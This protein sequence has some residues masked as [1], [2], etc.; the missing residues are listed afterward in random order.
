MLLSRNVIC[1]WQFQ[2]E[3]TTAM[4]QA[5]HSLLYWPTNLETSPITP[6]TN[7]A[8]ARDTIDHTP[9]IR[10][11]YAV[12]I[13]ISVGSSMRSRVLCF[14]DWWTI[15]LRSTYKVHLIPTPAWTL[16]AQQI[17]LRRR[18]SCKLLSSSPLCIRRLP[19]AR[20]TE[21]CGDRYRLRLELHYWMNEDANGGDEDRTVTFN[22]RALIN[23]WWEEMHCVTITARWDAAAAHVQKK[24]SKHDHGSI[25]LKFV[26][27]IGPRR[28]RVCTV[29]CTYAEHDGL[30]RW[31]R[32]MLLYKRPR[33]AIWC[34][35]ASTII[36]RF[37][38]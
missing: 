6:S 37:M 24:H 2:L 31:W 14:L 35:V 17:H 27:E 23:R 15:D 26:M 30:W 32:M 13:S 19:R 8:I 20:S 9:I 1:L 5:N 7:H 3:E 11:S 25:H 38:K 36:V 12:L 28:R 33:C 16:W 22:R 21:K 29:L 34:L 18:H 10:G 4:P